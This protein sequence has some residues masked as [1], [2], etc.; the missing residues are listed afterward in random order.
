MPS[1]GPT[2][3][4][5]LVAILR[6]VPGVPLEDGWLHL[7]MGASAVLLGRPGIEIYPAETG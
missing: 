5:G 6:G 1:V 7:E 3:A 4:L 2:G